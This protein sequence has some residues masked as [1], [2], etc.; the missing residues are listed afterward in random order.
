MVAGLP[1]GAAEAGT[2]ALLVGAATL[3]VVVLSRRFRDLRLVVPSLVGVGL[4]GA[5]LDWQA[6]GPGFIAGYASLIGLALRTPR[7]IAILAGIPVAAALSAEESY[8]SSNPGR[9]ILTVL[10]ASGLL[11]AISAFAAVSLDG[12]RHAEA[13]LAQEAATSEARAA[14]SGA[15]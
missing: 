14:G 13:L 6:D 9:T 1:A 15:G 7:R 12:R 11:F 10:F 2:V 5:G 4:F 8:Q 3:S